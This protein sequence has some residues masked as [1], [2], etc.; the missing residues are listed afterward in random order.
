MDAMVNWMQT[1]EGDI[2]YDYK[3]Q[4]V[5]LYFAIDALMFIFVCLPRRQCQYH[6]GTKFFNG[7]SSACAIIFANDS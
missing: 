5:T 3:V 2:H 7:I 6:T 1:A 4:G